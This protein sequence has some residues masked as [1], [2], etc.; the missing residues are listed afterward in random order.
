LP[1]V[2]IIHLRTLTSFPVKLSGIS[3]NIWESQLDDP[4]FHSASVTTTTMPS[5][6]IHVPL[7]PLDAVSPPVHPPGVVYFGI[8]PGVSNAEVFAH[9]QEGMYRT[10]LQAPWMNGKIHR[11]SPDTPGWRPGQLEIRYNPNVD[12]NDKP[13]CYQ[14]RYNELESATPYEE[15]KESGFPIDAFEDEALSWV[16]LSYQNTDF[17]AGVEIVAAQANFIPGACLLVTSVHHA[18]CDATGMAV[19]FKLWAENCRCLSLQSQGHSA[20]VPTLPQEIFDRTLPERIW[21]KEKTGHSVKEVDPATWQ[22]IGLEPPGPGEDGLVPPRRVK[23]PPRK[24][25][26]SSRVFYMSGTAFTKLR[27]KSVEEL[28]TTD[29]SGNDVFLALLWRSLMNARVTAKK[30]H[31]AEANIDMDSLVEL[32]VV[33]DVRPEFSQLMPSFYAGN[34]ILHHRPT[35]SLKA[36]VGPGSSVALVAQSIRTSARNVNHENIMD[37]YMLL[38]H[39][40]DY[41][42][43][44][45]PRYVTQDN[46]FFISSML[47]LPDENVSFGDQIFANGGRPEGS[48]PLVGNRNR[49]QVAACYIMPRKKHGGIE[50]ILTLFEDEWPFLLES[51]EFG[52]YAFLLV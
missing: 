37:A 3:K 36:L 12:D 48:R 15:L 43:L 40:P 28:G 34:A 23:S 21:A 51:E 35:I 49:S 33:H 41:S 32:S 5:K 16:S 6:L 25:I 30:H 22:L 11:Q 39:M 1:K 24:Q 7:S 47:L 17:E 19:F 44:Q 9:L 13:T 4:E 10:C 31:D 26:M 52:R 27:A 38:K 18:A 20:S 29:V 50:F 45:P 8:K 2:G 42:R 14:L 46:A